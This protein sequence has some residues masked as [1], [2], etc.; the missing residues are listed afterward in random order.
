MS[1]RTAPTRTATEILEAAEALFTAPPRQL[2][3]AQGLRAE[4]A[5]RMRKAGIYGSKQLSGNVAASRRV[6]R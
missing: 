4:N 3:Q 2:T 6:D 5:E 1:Y